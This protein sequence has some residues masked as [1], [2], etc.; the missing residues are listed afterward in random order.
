M[1]RRT[2]EEWKEMRD[3][4]KQILKETPKKDGIVI[5]A[6]FTTQRILGRIDGKLVD[7]VVELPGRVDLTLKN[8]G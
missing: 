5:F 4:T 3:K 7:N 8:R 1:I 2:K 6:D